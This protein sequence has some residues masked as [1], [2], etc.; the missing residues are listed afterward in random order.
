[1]G[2]GVSAEKYNLEPQLEEDLDVENIAQIHRSVAENFFTL[3][4]TLL[5]NSL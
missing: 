1:M 3:Q 4:Q 2:L 5:S